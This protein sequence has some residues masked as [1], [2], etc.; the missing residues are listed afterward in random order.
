M[1]NKTLANVFYETADLME[2]NGDDSFR[3][4]S[5]RRA[6]ET[7]ESFP[8][9]IITL[10]DDVKKLLEIPGIGKGMAANIQELIQ[11]GKLKL[12]QELLKKYQPSMLELLKIQG[13]GPKDH[14]PDLERI[15]GR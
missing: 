8:G 9:Q 6:A 7:I 11:T 1:D 5:Y 15:S 12:N 2:V 4:R 14:L 3:I 10:A 13:L